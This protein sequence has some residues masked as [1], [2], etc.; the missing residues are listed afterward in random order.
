MKTFKETISIQIPP[1]FVR[2]G[3]VA[4]VMDYARQK[5]QSHHEG[6]KLIT[7]SAIHDH[8]IHM[9]DGIGKEVLCECVFETGK[10]IWEIRKAYRQRNRKLWRKT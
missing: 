6:Q 4:E 5:L 10:S 7:F 1:Y 9:V 8:A 3:G 2:G